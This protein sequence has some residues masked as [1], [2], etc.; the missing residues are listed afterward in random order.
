MQNFCLAQRFS[1]IYTTPTDVSK[2]VTFNI[3]FIQNTKADKHVV[4]TR[5]LL[6]LTIA[7]ARKI[8]PTEKRFV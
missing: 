7:H 4:Q 1:M 3:G 6:E 8:F 2:N 5:G